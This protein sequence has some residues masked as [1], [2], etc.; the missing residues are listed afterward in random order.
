NIIDGKVLPYLLKKIRKHHRMLQN[1]MLMTQILFRLNE[2][3][4]KKKRN[5]L[6]AWS[7]SKSRHWLPQLYGL[8]RIG[9]NDIVTK[10]VH[11]QKQRYI[12]LN[13]C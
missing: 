7:L 2:P 10:N 11:Y 1:V 12:E 3:H 5:L 9:N 4:P 6:E 13:L 8:K